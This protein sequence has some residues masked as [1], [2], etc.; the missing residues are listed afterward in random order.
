MF[1]I[2]AEGSFV[3]GMAS[4][5]EEVEGL[6]FKLRQR[7]YQEPGNNSG[8]GSPVPISV[9]LNSVLRSVIHIAA[10]LSPRVQN[11]P[12]QTPRMLFLSE[13]NRSQI[14]TCSNSNFLGGFG[15]LEH[16]WCSGL[17]TV[18]NSLENANIVY[19]TSKMCR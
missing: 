5:V 7:T 3:P 13:R 8:V 18:G 19:P 16:P 9:T 11:V 1:L 2:G 4:S 17:C 6:A 15:P 12:L 10:S 14:L